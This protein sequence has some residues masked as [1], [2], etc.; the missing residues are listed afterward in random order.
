M[1]D[2]KQLGHDKQAGWTITKI[3]KQTGEEAGELAHQSC[4]SQVLR[5][6]ACRRSSE[7][8]N[9]YPCH[10]LFIGLLWTDNRPSYE[11]SMQNL[12][13]QPQMTNGH[14]SMLVALWPVFPRYG[15]LSKFKRSS[16]SLCLRHLKFKCFC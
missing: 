14:R 1:D 8:V 16:T 7:E 11:V 4:S 15:S 6:R 2:V 9:L 12:E 10:C 3:M 13:R 5:D